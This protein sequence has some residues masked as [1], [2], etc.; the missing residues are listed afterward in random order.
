MRFHTIDNVHH[1]HISLIINTLIAYI[2]LWPVS[3][4]HLDVYKRQNQWGPAYEADKAIE[5]IQTQKENKQPF[6]LVV[7]MNPPH[8]GYELVPDKYK[9]LYK[10]ID[11]EALCAVSYT[12]LF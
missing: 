11:V 8:T 10:D 12:H 1:S 4:T 3:Y 6:S 2:S 9:A 7:S 5:Y